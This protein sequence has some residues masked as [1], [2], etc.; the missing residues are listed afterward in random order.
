MGIVISLLIVSAN[1]APIKAAESSSRG[2][3]THFI[4]ATSTYKGNTGF[5]ISTF[6]LQVGYR[7]IHT[8]R[9]IAEHMQ[10][11]CGLRRINVTDGVASRKADMIHD[12]Q[13]SFP[14]LPF[15]KE[16]P[17]FNRVI[18]VTLGLPEFLY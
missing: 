4:G 7:P 17:V 11:P 15:L 8:F 12:I 5:P 3:E 10:L 13:F 2:I 16:F 1:W 9:C 14:L 6:G 18:P